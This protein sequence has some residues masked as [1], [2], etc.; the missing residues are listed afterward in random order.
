MADE[1]YEE[2]YAAECRRLVEKLQ[3]LAQKQRMS[4]RSLEKSMGVGDSAFNK[5]LNGKITLQFRHIL[6]ICDALGV[7]WREFFAEV[8]GLKPSPAKESDQEKILFLVRCGVLKPEQ[9][10]R[11]LADLPPEPALPEK[12]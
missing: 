12:D 6:M 3:D 7:D 11:L 8:Y 5:V 2:R 9:A 10:V 1:P 4:I